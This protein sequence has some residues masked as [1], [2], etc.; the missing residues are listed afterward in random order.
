MI[1]AEHSTQPLPALY[2]TTSTNRTI[3]TLQQ[4]ILQPLMIT[5]FVIVRHVLR[6]RAFK[7]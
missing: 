2:S 7:R 5:L 6:Q 1:E 4:T 3:G